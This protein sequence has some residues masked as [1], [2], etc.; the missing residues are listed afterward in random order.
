MATIESDQE[1]YTRVVYHLPWVT[2]G[3]VPSG[4]TDALMLW[5]QQRS[6]RLYLL[7]LRFCP[8][9]IL[10]VLEAVWPDVANH[11]LEHPATR[12]IVARFLGD[13]PRV[14]GREAFE[15]RA[16][17]ERRAFVSH[18]RDGVIHLWRTGGKQLD[19]S[20]G[21]IS[22]VTEEERLALDINEAN[23]EIIRGLA[24]RWPH[25]T[26]AQLVTEVREF[27]VQRSVDD[28]V[29]TAKHTAAQVIQWAEVSVT[30]ALVPEAR[31]RAGSSGIG[32]ILDELDKTQRKSGIPE[33]EIAE[34][35]VKM[36]D[37]L[38]SAA[39]KEG[40]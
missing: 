10:L 19:P 27:I 16:L 38:I 33:N 34:A 2:E 4:D 40:R 39:K 18:F 5:G 7:L 6:I 17:A 29:V 13:P 1:A 15:R 37:K 28:A 12:A 22:S 20:F 11:L 31:R 35:R 21:D 9:K 36:A 25:K 32:Q 23:I 14:F 3:F 26:N 8:D 30:E 24:L